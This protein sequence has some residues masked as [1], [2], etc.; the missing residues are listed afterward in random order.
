MRDSERVIYE[1]IRK[2]KPSLTETALTPSTRFDKYDISSL[3]MAMIL[4]EINDAF[5]IEIE[6]S[7]MMAL[8]TI[9]D[10]C[11]QVDQVRRQGE[12][13]GTAVADV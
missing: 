8:A 9:E 3:E 6:L 13:G 7:S 10:A 11:V 4:F 5:E 1:A 2:V 12:P